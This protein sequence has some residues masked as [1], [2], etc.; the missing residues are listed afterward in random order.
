MSLGDFA[1]AVR[2]FTKADELDDGWLSHHPKLWR[3]ECYRRLGDRERALAD[4]ACVPDDYVAISF[5]G[6]PDGCKRHVVEAIEQGNFD[7]LPRYCGL[8]RR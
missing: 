4:C 6:R 8:P 7:E 3:A 5:L 2:D 1:D